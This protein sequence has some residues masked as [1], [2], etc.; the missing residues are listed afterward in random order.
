MLIVPHMGVY[1]MVVKDDADKLSSQDYDLL[2]RY[3]DAVRDHLREKFLVT[4]FV[5]VMVCMPTYRNSDFINSNHDPLIN[6]D[7]IIFDDDIADSK[8]F[9]SKLLKGKNYSE[10]KYARTMMLDD[11]NDF[12]AHNI[13]FYWDTGIKELE[14]PER[15]PLVFLS[16]NRLN[17]TFAEEIKC[18]L[19]LRGIFVWRAP[20]DVPISTDY[21]KTET[22]AIINC[23]YFVIMI[24]TSSQLSEEVKY[25]FDKAL[26]VNKSIL[27]VWVDDC[28]TNEYYKAKLGQFTYRKM[29][30]IEP[31]IMDD[32]EQLIKR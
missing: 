21:K 26:E 8:V 9:M 16:Y 15:P 17:Q 6:S 11:I 13:S 22:E 29:T 23:D 30:K 3:R 12:M 32:I 31:V 20:E 19:E 24:S 25:E 14:R 18:E 5:N 4:P 2:N 27:P 1:I 10:N 28:E 7:T